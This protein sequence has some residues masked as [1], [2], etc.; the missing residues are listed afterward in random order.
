M[1]AAVTAAG[2][3]G[4]RREVYYQLFRVL[5]VWWVKHMG[6]AYAGVEAGRADLQL[7]GRGRFN[8]RDTAIV[9]VTIDLRGER[10]SAR[11]KAYVTATWDVTRTSPELHSVRIGGNFL[12]ANWYVDGVLDD[13][14]R[15]DREGT[16]LT[17]QDAI[18][19]FVRQFDG[20]TWELVKG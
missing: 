15:D 16:I 1:L 7:R 20:R 10:S 14:V 17:T 6:V 12:R 2:E 3:S 5:P 8:D 18:E 9:R 4:A 11:R 13:Y 19:N